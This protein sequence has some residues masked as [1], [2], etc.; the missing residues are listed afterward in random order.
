[1]DESNVLKGHKTFRRLNPN[2]CVHLYEIDESNVPP[3]Q[4]ITNLRKRNINTST[5][6]KHVYNSCYRYRKS[7][8]GSRNNMQHLLKLLVENEYVYHCRNYHDSDDVGD[9]FW[10]RPDGIKLFNTFF[11]VLVLDSTYKTN[12]YRLLFLEFVG[13]TST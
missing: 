3:R 9:I 11:T 2:E 13:N 8:R 12:K 4:M 5:T 1:M 6:I 7:I 10:V